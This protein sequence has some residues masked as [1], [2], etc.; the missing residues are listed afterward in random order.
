MTTIYDIELDAAMTAMTEAMSITHVFDD[1]FSIRGGGLVKYVLEIKQR[2]FLAWHDEDTAV[3]VVSPLELWD[4]NNLLDALDD[5]LVVLSFKEMT[6][7][8]FGGIAARSRKISSACAP[9]I[10]SLT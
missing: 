1:S 3:M 5:P 7:A 8:A 6:G 10:S 9:R 4:L 2:L